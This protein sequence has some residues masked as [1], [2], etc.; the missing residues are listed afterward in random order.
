VLL[1]Y[2]V[3]TDCIVT[4]NWLGSTHV[5]VI[6][7]QGEGYFILNVSEGPDGVNSGE[8]RRQ[9]SKNED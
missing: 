7:D 2:S 4:D 5:S 9:F 8:A 6:V 1:T 3:S